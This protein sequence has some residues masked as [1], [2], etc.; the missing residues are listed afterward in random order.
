MI[1][2][3]FLTFQTI[4]LVILKHFYK[5]EFVNLHLLTMIIFFGG[6]YFTYVKKF[7]VFMNTDI[8]GLPLQVSNIF[9]HLIP[10]LYVWRRYPI[11][12]NY[13]LETIVYLLCYIYIFKPKK[14]YYMRP[15]EYIKMFGVL[16][17]ICVMFYI[18]E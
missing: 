5:I 9:L 17:F 2:F 13:F 14:L 3:E 11:H 1:G 18:V 7:M 4:Y 15:K 16:V 10:F 8:T 12:K 6:F